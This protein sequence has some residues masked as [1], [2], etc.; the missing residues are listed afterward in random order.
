MS[1][2]IRCAGKPSQNTNCPNTDFTERTINFTLSIPLNE[3][4]LSETKFT[5]LLYFFADRSP[6]VFVESISWPRF[7]KFTEKE[8]D[9][10][11]IQA[12]RSKKT[13]T[14]FI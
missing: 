8:K 1:F 4:T 3:I 12:H 7:D 9:K 13:T 6:A 2:Q 11:Q 10:V 5:L 14:L